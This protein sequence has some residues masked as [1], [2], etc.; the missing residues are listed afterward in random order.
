MKL[1]L[2]GFIV[3][4]ISIHLSASNAMQLRTLILQKQHDTVWI[5]SL[6]LVCVVI[7]LEVGFGVVLFILAKGD[8]RDSRLQIRL[9]RFNCI[10]MILAILIG[11][12]NVVI[13]GL[14]LS[15]NPKAFLDRSTLEM[16]E[17]RHLT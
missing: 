4:L 7:I 17:N 11:V 12:L 10:A 15:T 5:I 6:L 3:N 14:M 1:L 16:I 9:E 2:F 13:N 8:I